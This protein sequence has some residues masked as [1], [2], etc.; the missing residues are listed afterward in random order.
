MLQLLVGQS[1][2]K[3]KIS[4]LMPVYNTEKY[5]GQ[6]IESILGQTF[7]EFEF[8]I[9]DDH[10][11]DNSWDIINNH[12]RN[13]RRIV[14]LRNTV[15]VRATK[16]LNRGLRVAKGKYMVRMDADDWSYP[17]RL[18]KQFDFMEK[19][20]DVG[21]SGGTVEICDENLKVLNLRR[22]PL[23]DETAR[24][25]IFRYSPFAHPATIWRTKVVKELGGYNEN[26]PLTQDYELYFRVG[27]KSTFA[28]LS[29]V[30]LKLRTHDDSSSLARGKSQE[31]F[32][33]YSRIKAFLE[34]GY[35]M[36]TFDK[37][38]TFLQMLSLIFIPQKVKFWLFNFIR[39][40]L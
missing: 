8:I 32:A 13:D 24:K 14:P 5:V 21:V 40:V 16:S 12:A 23:T 31:Q 38:Y 1:M 29:D 3:P 33:L 34:Y 27:Q 6:A 22:Y 2:K 35:N 39:R 36:T 7:E 25:I 19:H 9:V 28:N 20:P 26:I 17:Y 10:S 15:N 30:I 4:V 18:Q 11:A 37:A